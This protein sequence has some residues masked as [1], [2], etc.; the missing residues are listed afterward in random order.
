MAWIYLAASVETHSDS[1]SGLEP[2][3]TASEISMPKESCSVVC[4]TEALSLHLSGTTFQLSRDLCS[5]ASTSLSGASLAKISAL[6]G[7]EQAWV[8]SEA[9]F[10]TRLCAWPKKRSP[11][12][13]SLKTSLPSEHAALTPLSGPFP[14][15]GMTVAGTLYPLTTWER[16]TR[17]SGG[18]CWPT[19]RASDGA[20]GGPGQKFGA[21]GMTLPAAVKLWPTPT[22][23]DWKESGLE[24]AAQARKSPCLPAS[25]RLAGESRPGSLSPM[26]TEWLM[27]F[28]IGWTEL[29][30]SVT[31]W[32]RPK[33]GKRSKD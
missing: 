15:S 1:A 14:A 16:R 4:Q 18:F 24:P 10:F 26:W 20:K 12:S 29:D 30:A 6:L 5:P 28:P 27:G 13:Y 25:V 17:G 31:Q 33:R 3:P 2:S 8:E 22:A 19:V 11:H 21:G 7:M 32:C 9:G 23:R